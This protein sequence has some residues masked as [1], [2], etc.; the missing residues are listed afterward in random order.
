M[1]ATAKGK[2]KNA[3]KAEAPGGTGGYAPAAGELVRRGGTGEGG[4]KLTR[5]FEV[6]QGKT[7]RYKK[8]L[9]RHQDSLGLAALRG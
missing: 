4:S 2:L 6:G 5:T 9:M 8:V 7:K 3:G 1:R